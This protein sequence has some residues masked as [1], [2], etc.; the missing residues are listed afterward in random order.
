MGCTQSES[1]LESAYRPRD[2][3]ALAT[4]RKKAGV[5][6]DLTPSRLE[7][8]YGGAA[9]IWQQAEGTAKSGNAIDR[10]FRDSGPPN[11]WRRSAKSLRRNICISSSVSS[12]HRP[13][14]AR[15]LLVRIEHV[16]G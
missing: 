15:G 16:R 5:V 8:K 4:T 12:F 7:D 10:K 1:P 6:R 9:R 11:R 14:L 3:L 2:A 13:I